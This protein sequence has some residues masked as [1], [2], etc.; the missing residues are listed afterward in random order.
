MK[1]TV[2]IRIYEDTKKRLK[3]CSAIDDKD[4]IKLLDEYSH[5]AVRE[6]LGEHYDDWNGPVS[7]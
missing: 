6:R 1:R 7:R 5:H 4:M 3:L 2:T